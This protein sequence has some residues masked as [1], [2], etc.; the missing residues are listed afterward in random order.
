[1]KR[2]FLFAIAIVGFSV[3]TQA[4]DLKFGFKAGVNF[5]TINSDNPAF[6]DID[7]RTGYHIGAVAQVSLM[8]MLAL[9]PEILYSAQGVKDTDIDY[10]NVPILLKYKFAKVFSIEAGP[11]FGF[12]VNDDFK[13]GAE[14]ESFDFSGAVGAGVEISSFFA[15]VRYNI[16]FTDV[17]ENFDGKNATFQVSVGY[18]I[19]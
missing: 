11:Q 4:Q 2:L 16:G 17:N 8:D 10:L 15:Q 9:Q 18:Y 19:F 6:D 1:M 12:V 3:S 7:G 13:N 5:A 14:P